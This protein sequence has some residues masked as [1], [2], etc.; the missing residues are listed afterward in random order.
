MGIN[1][2]FKVNDTVKLMRNVDYLGNSIKKGSIGKV[3]MVI[4]TNLSNGNVDLLF[5]AFGYLPQLV[6]AKDFK[7]IEK[8]G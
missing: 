5:V 2:G 4:N 6:F 8:E 3:F 1:N 7:I